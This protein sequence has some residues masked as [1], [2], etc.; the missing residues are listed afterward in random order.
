MLQNIKIT[1]INSLSRSLVYSLAR[2]HVL[3]NSINTTAP[4]VVYI[5]VADL[6]LQNKNL[7]FAKKN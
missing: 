3:V 1:K 7:F 5:Y 4:L 6:I 2:V